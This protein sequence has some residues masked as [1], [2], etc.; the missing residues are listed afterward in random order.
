MRPDRVLLLDMLVAARDAVSFLGDCSYEEFLNDRMRQM[1]VVKAVEVVGEAAA[2]VSDVFRAAKPTLPWRQII[3][4]RHRL[5][6]DY[7]GIDVEQIWQTV[8]DD[9]P[10]LIV[11]LDR[12]VA[13][14][15]D[16]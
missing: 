10:G 6:H 14:G 8:K 2:R 11:I 15:E 3:G 16:E 9:L 1:A 12:W 13:S 5:V 7:F 4:M